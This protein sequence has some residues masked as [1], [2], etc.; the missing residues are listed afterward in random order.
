VARARTRVIPDPY[1]NHAHNCHKGCCRCAETNYKQETS[2]LS[3]DFASIWPSYAYMPRSRNLLLHVATGSSHRLHLHKGRFTGGPMSLAHVNSV[4]YNSCISIS[5]STFQ[6]QFVFMHSLCISH[7]NENYL[8]LIFH[9]YHASCFDHLA[10]NGL[11][12][13]ATQFLCR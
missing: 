12:R 11:L 13:L 2:K 7:G 3:L 4:P 10:L 1:T 6:G 8:T 5:I 9:N